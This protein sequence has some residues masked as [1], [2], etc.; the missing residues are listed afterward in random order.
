MFAADYSIVKNSVLILQEEKVYPTL[1]E[2][3][4]REGFEV[5]KLDLIENL[6]QLLQSSKPDLL[7]M[8]VEM[9]QGSGID[10]CYQLK[11]K[12]EEESTFIILI[13]RKRED[14]SM[15]AGLD[16]GADDY[17]V[18]PIQ[19]RVLLSRI[20]ALLKRKSKSVES[21]LDE[22]LVIDRERYLIV[23]K[24]KEYYLPKKEFEILSL[25]YA[26]PNQV[27]SREEIKTSVWDDFEKVRSRTIDVHIRKI[28]EQ[29]G[30]E[31]IRTVKGVGYCLNLS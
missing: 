21:I 27:F 22:P 20:K 12:N 25:L 8:P 18:H 4:S 16:S 11:N 1:S 13:S 7:L 19:E 3:L 17:I 2:F 15:I 26:N 14:F 29:I 28:R 30:E 10:L 5:S 9:K 23:K 24:G 31:L 6:D